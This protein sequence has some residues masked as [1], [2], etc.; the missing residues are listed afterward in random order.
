MANWASHDSPKRSR[1]LLVGF[2]ALGLL[3]PAIRLTVVLVGSIARVRQDFA[4]DAYYYALIAHNIA[5]GNGS[6]FGGIVLTNGYQPLWQLL[7]VPIAVVSSGDAQV[8]LTFVLAAIFF[9]SFVAVAWRF[10]ERLGA[11]TEGLYATVY[12]ITIGAV[13]GNQ[14]FSGMEF[15]IVVPAAMLVL[16]L[17]LRTPQYIDQGPSKST[18][19]GILLGLAVLLL[20]LSRLDAIALPV[21]YALIILARQRDPDMWRAWIVAALVVASGCI[22]YAAFNLATFGTPVPVSGLAKALGGG[23]WESGVSLLRTYF[24]FGGIGPVTPMWLGL[25]ATVVSALALWLLRRGRIA[26]QPLFSARHDVSLS[27]II[28]ALGLGQL[29]QLGYYAATSSWHLWEWYFYYIPLQFVAAGVVVVRRALRARRLR[30]LQRPLVAVALAILAGTAGLGLFVRDNPGTGWT[31]SSVAVGSWIDQNTPSEAVIAM[32]DRAG[33]V[34]W[35]S[36]RRAV[37]L[38]GL[39]EDLN[40]LSVLRSS[41]IPQHLVEQSVDYYVRGSTADDTA[42]RAPVPGRAGC[43]S[44]VEPG[45]GQGP[46]S[47][48]VVCDE[49]LLYSSTQE[50]GSQWQIWMF[51]PQLQGS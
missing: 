9:A 46:K 25:Q 39:V 40:Y 36:N 7:L 4:D 45:Q 28:Q 12:A 34:L 23:T 33:G 32:G 13:F 29:L 21:V 15:A 35:A 2:L 37:Q 16:L 43:W 22:T 19:Y 49:D 51:R 8:R 3:Y 17:L 1:I 42:G 10:S 27:H 30:V 24:E 41:T 18:R 50:D 38:E 6:T 48:V 11:R 5:E 47:S 14:F 26:E 20:A 31:T 44:F